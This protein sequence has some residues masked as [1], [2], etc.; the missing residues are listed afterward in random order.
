MFDSTRLAV[1]L[2]GV[3]LVGAC[4]GSVAGGTGGNGASSGAT[5]LPCDLAAVID[6]K[7]ASCHSNPPT[8]GAPTPLLS[9]SD[10]RAP[11][12][13]DP[14]VTMAQQSV[15]R[16]QAATAAMPPGGGASASDVAAFQQWIDAG[17]PEGTCGGTSNPDPAFSGPSVCTS[18]KTWTL[19]TDLPDAQQP[20]MEPGK[21]CNSCHKQQFATVF[22]AAGTVYPTGHEPDECL[23]VS[24]SAM[25]DVV[26]HIVGSDGVD[27][28]L[29]PNASGNFI[30]Y[31]S[32]A[33]P[34]TAKVV[35]SKGERVMSEPQ[36]DGDC[37]LC[38][39]DAAGGNMSA[40]AGRI[41]IPY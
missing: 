15:K 12:K 41:V 23:G 11:A 17:Y 40:A 21:A 7:C 22:A 28:P 29:S 34:Y 24:G 36:N 35:S 13:T 37:N 3:A 39:T 5:G 9:A 1:G 26:V 38:H 4:S 27:H 8:A 16:M 18:M 6:A 19:G 30:L 25:P 10:L 33:L 20:L 32:L 2:F 31:G 14:S